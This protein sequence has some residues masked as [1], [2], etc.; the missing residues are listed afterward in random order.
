MS[1]KTNCTEMNDHD[2]VDNEPTNRS[3]SSNLKRKRND[4][5]A[6]ESSE[7]PP[8]KKQ[9]VHLQQATANKTVHVWEQIRNESRNR[10]QEWVSFLTA[11]LEPHLPAVIAAIL[12][13]F[14]QPP[15]SFAPTLPRRPPIGE[16]TRNWIDWFSK[17]EAAKKEL[18]A[19]CMDET[20]S[21]CVVIQ[22]GVRYPERLIPLA[23]QQEGCLLV[24]SWSRQP[25]WTDNSEL[26][27]LLMSDE[28]KPMLPFLPGS[29]VFRSPAPIQ[30]L[31]EN[32]HWLCFEDFN[33]F[34]LFGVSYTEASG[35]RVVEFQYDTESVTKR[36]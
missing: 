36:H 27:R 20:L 26:S 34:N 35:V 28:I 30:E 33:D 18:I 32:T 4:D 13:E 12:S 22:C 24:N 14:Y 3:S 17:V 6:Q 1:E 31:Y 29:I 11:L 23:K 5:G 7:Q 16:D 21:D 25:I 8:P 9:R 10:K 19:K 15:F 2:D